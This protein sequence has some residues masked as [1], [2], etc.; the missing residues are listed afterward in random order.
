MDKNKCPDK[1][2]L[3]KLQCKN[4]KKTVIHNLHNQI[5]YAH[6]NFE[7]TSMNSGSIFPKFNFSVIKHESVNNFYYKL[8]TSILH[9]I[10]ANLS[11]MRFKYYK[12]YGYLTTILT[13]SILTIR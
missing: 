10:L 7:A 11:G 3:F 13:I 5:Y 12:I 1:R 2:K 4:T 8:N 9:P 6:V